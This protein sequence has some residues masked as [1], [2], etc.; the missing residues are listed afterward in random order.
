MKRTSAQL[1]ALAREALLQRYTAAVGAYVILALIFLFQYFLPIQIS[2][3]NEAA[4]FLG[5][6]LVSLLL[7][8]LF[9]LFE[10]GAVCL[11]LNISR[12]KSYGLGDL[13]YAFRHNP[14]T[15]LLVGLALSLIRILCQLP[16]TLYNYANPIWDPT[17]TTHETLLT[18]TGIY[19]ALSLLGSLISFLLTVPLLLSSHLLIDNSN[20]S[21]GDA[22]RSSIRLMHGN[23]GRLIY[24]QLSFL[25]FWI[26]GAL[27]CGLAF[28]WIYPYVNMTVVFFY[29][30]LLGELEAAQL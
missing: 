18:V 8:L 26:L 3:E 28:L 22:L 9:S 2:L 15:F 10:A 23:K 13:L 4:A 5:A 14:D 1:K 17:A 24:I 30:E 12:N 25:G 7:S 21:A 27:S 19:L 29:R 16:A 11:L 20:M 6:H